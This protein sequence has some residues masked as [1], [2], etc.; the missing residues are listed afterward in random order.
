MKLI[1]LTIMKK[2]IFSIFLLFSVIGSIIAQDAIIKRTGEEIKAK[3]KAVTDKEIEYVRFDNLEGPIYKI[4]KSDVLLIMY[5]NG[6]KD[7]F[8]NETPATNTGNTATNNNVKKGRPVPSNMERP[9]Q[10]YY[11]Y[12][13]FDRNVPLVFLGIDFYY[14]KLIGDKNFEDP[15]KLFADINTLFVTEKGKYDVRGAVRKG[16]LTY[17][18]SIVEKRN[19]SVDEKVLTSNTEETLSYT[20]LQNIVDEYDLSAAGIKDG[21]ALIMICES[22]NANRGNGAYYYVA[23]DVVS[24]KIVL[25][26]RIMGVAGGNGP[27]NYWARSVYE[28]ITKM[29]DVYFGKWKAVSRR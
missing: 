27:R 3:V 5:A 22:L 1:I 26:D 7:I 24:K 11:N 23:F 28:S 29:Q 2:I 15:K 13:F 16:G 17:Q 19:Q 8:S 4:A 9:A 12:D 14:S 25:S 20:D 18:Y 6:S 10:R 21:L